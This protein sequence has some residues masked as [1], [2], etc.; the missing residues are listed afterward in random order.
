MIHAQLIGSDDGR[1]I[2]E[3]DSVTYSADEDWFEDGISDK[4]NDVSEY[5]K[6][7]KGVFSAP[8]K[9]G[10]SSTSMSG[11]STSHPSST[12]TYV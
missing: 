3:D 11:P 9:S 10:H 1:L 12:Y 4:P 6:K 5:A 7:A 2:G 8:I